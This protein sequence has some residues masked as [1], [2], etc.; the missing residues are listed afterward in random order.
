MLIHTKP[1]RIL[2]DVALQDSGEGETVGWVLVA[3]VRTSAA[4]SV[5]RPRNLGT[6]LKSSC[7]SLVFLSSPLLHPSPQ[8]H[9]YRASRWSSSLVMMAQRYAHRQPL[10]SSMAIP[11]GEGGQRPPPPPPPHPCAYRADHHPPSSG[12]TTEAHMPL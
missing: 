11:G 9:P 7:S 3:V 5:R 10:T 6:R 1:G 12:L 8:A 2:L 4:C